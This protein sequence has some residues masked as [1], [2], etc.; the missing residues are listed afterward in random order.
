MY[1]YQIVY[2]EA[3]TALIQAVSA[4]RLIITTP[5]ACFHMSIG[6]IITD[7]F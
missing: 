4:N 2:H 3:L 5:L 7:I 1:K 6:V